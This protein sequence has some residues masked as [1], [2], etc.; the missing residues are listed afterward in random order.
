MHAAHPLLSGIQLHLLDS[1]A[2]GVML[3]PASTGEIAYANSAAERMFG[4][5]P[6]EMV[7]QHATVL[8]DSTNAV[9]VQLLD[10][11]REQLK[12]SPT[13][14][15]DLRLRRKDG[16]LVIAH[17]KISTVEVEGVNY[18]LCLE[19]D[20]TRQK[21][22]EEALDATQHQLNNIT[23][24][25]MLGFITWDV[26]GRI[27]DANDEF[28]RMVGYSREDLTSGLVSWAK[29]T[30]PEYAAYD[31]AG[32]A[33]LRATGRCE[34][35]EKE[36]IRKDGTRVPILIGAVTLNR[37]F[38][39]GVSFTLD[40]TKR[41]RAEDL[42]RAAQQRFEAFMD[43]SHAV[44][45]MKDS[46]GRYVYMNRRFAEKF[47]HHADS[48]FGR[49]DEELWPA[50]IAQQFREH[51][52]EVLRSNEPTQVLQSTPMPSGDRL[53]WQVLKFPFQDERG[54]RYI[55]GMALD[56]TEKVKAEEQ[57]RQAEEQVR[58]AQKMEAVGRL[59]GGVAHDFNNLLTIING[60]SELLIEQLSQQ[61]PGHALAKEVQDAGRR[62]AALTRQLLAFSRRQMLQPK[63]LD[64]NAV[65]LHLDKILR[66]SLGPDIE[67]VMQLA[68]TVGNV[69]VDPAQLDQAIINL[70][71]NARDAMPR[72]G[73][74]TLETRHIWIGEEAPALEGDCLPGR[75]IRLVVADSGEG[76]DGATLGQ[77]FEPFFTTKASGKGTGLGLAMVYGFVRQS[78]GQIAVESAPGMGTRFIIDLPCVEEFVDATEAPAEP[79]QM[80]LGNET[81]LVVE[82]EEGVR[83]WT[84]HVLEMCGYRVLEASHG[85][86][87]L[88]LGERSI[89]ILVTDVVMPKM[90]GRQV[91]E[92]L[93]ASHP[94]LKV[95]F[96]SGYTDDAMIRR[97]ILSAGSAFLQKPFTAHQL[98]AKVRELLD[99]AAV[100]A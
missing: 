72:G 68:P 62:A 82:D 95:L 32:L 77:I 7:G 85:A 9:S 36:Y 88:A 56:I 44:A 79:T 34:P 92:A 39:S 69:L 12:Q 8:V 18:Y 81:V 52:A 90:S 97:G 71:V 35:F 20:I 11:L 41:K 99:T 15:G 37:E 17:V 46:E 40:L 26:E 53:H 48:W 28:L 57:L 22:A 60:C 86:Q 67:I 84:R 14:T 2:E 73:R 19:E 55:G 1:M 78:G 25:D 66:R 13:Y 70:A 43:H 6:G 27:V 96:V 23:S 21:L 76:I 30:P 59:A 29:M 100:R 10:M 93:V 87:A 94:D 89:D 74:L 91:A 4:Y 80:P 63:V 50:E 98:A 3:I 47:E 24:S 45:F 75:Y 31:E 38:T 54:A 58:Q 65:L 33:Q 64:L 61:H 51:D 16:A 49:V 42:A 83:A 5:S